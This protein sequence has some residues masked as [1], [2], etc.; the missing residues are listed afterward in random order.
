MKWRGRENR[1]QLR[2]AGSLAAR[3][4]LVLLLVAL[5]ACRARLAHELVAESG[6]VGPQAV[7][8]RSVQAQQVTRCDWSFHQD[9]RQS[10]G[11]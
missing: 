9:F 2:A 8:P 7:V 3:A 4:S 11:P 5:S 10:V 6:P 1:S